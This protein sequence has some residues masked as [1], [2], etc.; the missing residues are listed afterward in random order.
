MHTLDFF[1]HIE[2]IEKSLECFGFD[3]DRKD[4]FES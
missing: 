4:S 3:F 1:T 2:S